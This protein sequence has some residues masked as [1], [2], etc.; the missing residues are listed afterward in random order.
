MIVPPGRTNPTMRDL[1]LGPLKRDM[2]NQQRNA[3]VKPGPSSV[4][5]CQRKLGFQILYPELKVHHASGWASYKGTVLH[6]LYDRLVETD[7]LCQDWKHDLALPAVVEAVTGGSLD[8]FIGTTVVDE[9][10]PGDW[11]FKKAAAGE[12][13]FGYYGQLQVYGLGAEMLGFTVER[14]GLFV[15][16]MSGDDLDRTI[17]T[18]WDY[19]RPTAIRLLG[20]A[21]RIRQS[22]LEPE[23]DRRAILDGLATKDDWC[24]T[25][26]ALLAGM[27]PG[28]TKTRSAWRPRSTPTKGGDPFA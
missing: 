10:Y 7:P 20:E 27:C 12:V 11:S 1:L 2:A 5:G 26:D 13:N 3:Q 24:S 23:A 19:D 16:P 14:V 28:E 18:E 25:C 4:A 6:A 9:K 21:E 15:A 22:G 17:Y 8:L